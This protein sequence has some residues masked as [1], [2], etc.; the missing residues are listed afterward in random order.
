MALAFFTGIM[1]LVD[2]YAFSGFKVLIQHLQPTTQRW[3][4]NGFWILSGINIILL[5]TF[6]MLPP[7]AFWGTRL[8]I[9]TFLFAQYFG[10]FVFIIF[11]FLDDIVRLFKWLFASF[12][13]EKPIINDVASS[14][15]IS[16]SEFIVKTGVLAGTGL[17]TALSWGILSGAYNY[18]VK[19]RVV[20]LKNLPPAFD[21]FRILQISDI[22]SG[23]FW[24]T[25]AVRK[26][27]EMIENE[28]ADV[29]FFTGDL[30]NDKAI[31]MKPYMNVF[32]KLKAPHGV[33][34]VLGNHDYGDYVSWHSPEAKRKNMEE[35][36]LYFKK[37][38]WHLLR[39][40]NVILKNGM[41]SIALIGVENW[42]AT[43]RFQ[44]LGDIR[45][46]E[47]GTEGM[48]TRVLLS[49]DPTHWGS[50]ISRQYQD[51]DLTLS[52]HTHGGQL[53]IDCCGI[54][55]SPAGWIYPEWCG[56][57][58][59][60][61]SPSPQYLYVNQGLGNIGYSGRVGILPEI[62]LITLKRAK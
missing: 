11:L 7:H 48:S 51:I 30:V 57:Y 41:D 44:R 56:L 24:N 27:V 38:G 61:D 39:N 19:R 42:G 43:Q 10:K 36:F 28:N 40:E 20:S 47:K 37:L 49:H 58:S 26:G 35:L 46:A 2:F 33:F 5:I 8:I 45:K 4:K 9:A 3:L 25:D 17:I 22:H 60:P 31:E 34:S 52:G 23:S 50:I 21:G 12:R 6:Q 55:W 32:N 62:T 29:I 13:T 53:G 14:K 59:N 1:V 54:H 16:R 18:R 15:W